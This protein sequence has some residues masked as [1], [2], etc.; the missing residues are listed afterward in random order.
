MCFNYRKYTCIFSKF[1]SCC[2]H[3]SWHLLLA[4]KIAWDDSLFFKFSH[5]SYFFVLLF[6]CLRAVLNLTLKKLS[7]L[8]FLSSYVHYVMVLLIQII[9]FLKPFV[10]IILSFSST[11]CRVSPLTV[12]LS[13]FISY[14][15]FLAPLFPQMHN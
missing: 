14:S 8:I 4:Y 7:P 5:I 10:I 13:L 12:L 2:I 11:T 1:S 9:I 3:S 6:Y 15:G